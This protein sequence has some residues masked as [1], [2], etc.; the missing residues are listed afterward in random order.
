MSAGPTGPG[1]HGFQEALGDEG[2]AR[3]SALASTASPT[4][5]PQAL[6]EQAEKSRIRASGSG[7]SCRTQ[8]R[9]HAAQIADSRPARPVSE[10]F[11]LSSSSA[12]EGLAGLCETAVVRGRAGL[13]DAVERTRCTALIAS[14]ERVRGSRG[15]REEVMAAGRRCWRCGAR[16]FA[17]PR[18]R[19][20]LRELPGRGDPGA[21]RAL[22]PPALRPGPGLPQARDDS[23]SSR[24][25]GA[26]S[27]VARDASQGALAAAAGA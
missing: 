2:R 15:R 22:R 3:S 14:R 17:P 12:L 4:A 8:I 21:A 24:P 7:G 16:H 23:R 11:A 6:I 5:L 19:Q 18:Q 1:N 10:D 13:R 25:G 20:V 26:A 27:V 9:V